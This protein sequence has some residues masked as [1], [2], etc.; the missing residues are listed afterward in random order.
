VLKQNRKPFA[1]ALIALMLALP[2]AMTT[3]EPVR[4]GPVEALLVSEQTTISPGTPFT[5]GLLLKIDPDW[6]VYWKNPGDSGL[7]T[8]IEWSLP[9]GFIARP[10]QWPLPERIV[11]QDLVTYGYSHQVLLPVEII[12]PRTVVPGTVVALRA[13]A[14]WLACRQECTPGSVQ[15]S[16]SVPVASGGVADSRWAELFRT[17][18]SRLPVRDTAVQLT[19]SIEGNR[20]ALRAHGPDIRK[21]TRGLFIP[22]VAETI[23]DS[24]PQED[25]VSGSALTLWLTVPD[26]AAPPRQLGGIL[27]FSDPGAQ[28]AIEVDGVA[29]SQA[30]RAG[31]SAPSG[32]AGGIAGLLLALILAFAGGLLL[33]LMPCVLPVLSL[34][35]LS[36]VRSAEH[37]RGASFRH[38][39]LYSAGV[40]VSFWLIAGILVAF[41]A[42]GQLLGWGFQFQDPVVVAV[43]ATV[44]F[45][46]G[47][48]LFGVFEVG[49]SITALA[50]R[51]GG[52]RRGYGSFVSGLFA[53]AVA[54][55]CTAPFMGGALGYALTRPLPVAFGIFTAL[56]L[57]LAAPYL[58]LSAF[59][60]LVR[61]LPKPGRWMETLRQLMGF[62]M[63]G[64]VIWMVFVLQALTRA[65]GVIA[66]LSALL[67]AGTGAWVWGRWGDITRSRG[68]RIVSACVAL[69]LVIGGPA[70]ATAF[71]RSSA[72]PRAA[73]EASA[74]P[75]DPQAADPWLPWSPEKVA[76]LRQ[77]GVPVFVDFTARWCI[78][79]QVNERVA[80]DNPEVRDRFRRLGIATLRADWTDRSELIAR[81]LADQGR[82]G[83]PL[84]LLYGPGAADPV[85]LPE[86]LTPGIVLAALGPA[87]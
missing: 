32:S 45:L 81:A 57:G 86:V 46:I 2:A 11:Q 39:L 51:V 36:F 44:F 21:G 26:K 69:L 84:Y 29:V 74:R 19:A 10:M 9:P 61:R 59:P 73:A 31:L 65:T 60:G 55:P 1:I 87:R 15:L 41:R 30:A 14:G 37:G 4:D 67:A 72:Q 28:R 53:T 52:G 13:K 33:N 85:I 54:T 47:L 77:R 49:T 56:A 79:C 62:P 63:M 64:A 50:A 71:L 22:A 38:G 35:V 20:I 82:A 70:V 43:T 68:A 34:K 3:A 83:V 18:R 48:N 23:R 5:A 75:G 80:L 25:S 42:G 6:H 8:T 24:I 7:P 76:E 27:V 66:L 17:A 16:V 58:V 40:L 78:T 12:P